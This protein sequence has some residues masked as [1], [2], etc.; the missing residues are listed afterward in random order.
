MKPS[1]SRRNST[2]ALGIMK[3]ISRMCTRDVYSINLPGRELDG[4]CA[5]QYSHIVSATDD[6]VLSIA[7]LP[8]RESKGS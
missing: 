6:Y 1:V 4:K 8:G 7:I 5:G 2:W 3:I